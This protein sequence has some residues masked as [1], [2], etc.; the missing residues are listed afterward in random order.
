MFLADSI[1][2]APTNNDIGLFVVCAATIIGLVAA[3]ISIASYFATRREVDDLKER[4]A[5][6]EEL[7]EKRTEKLHNRINRLLAGQMLIAGKL[8]VALEQHQN[9]LDDILRDL[10]AEER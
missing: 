10:E 2:T 4:V 1:A 8:G 6:I 7:M 3:L 5:N 9:Q